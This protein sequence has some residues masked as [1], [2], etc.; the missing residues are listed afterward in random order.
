MKRDWLSQ[1]LRCIRC[2]GDG[3]RLEESGGVCLRCQAKYGL[4]GEAVSFLDESAISTYAIDETNN[5]SDHPYDGNAGEL[6]R[7]VGDAGGWVL[8]CG[9]GFKSTSYSHVVQLE[10][11]PYPQVD[12][13]APNQELPFRDGCFDCVF[14][15]NVLEHVE[16]PFA[17]ASELCRVLKPRGLLY[18]DIPFLQGEHGYPNHYFNATR[19]GLLR[20]FPTFSVRGHHVPLSGHP[21]FMLQHFIEVYRHGLP[22]DLAEDFLNLKMRDVLERSAT[23]WLDSPVC[24]TLSETAQWQIASTTQAILQKTDGVGT[25]PFDAATLPGFA[26]T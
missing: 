8:D 25:T 1:N 21:I 5:V 7:Q 10:I 12:V 11:K 2:H 15:L 17:S 9:A 26:D 3:I 4:M 24:A 19:S 16:N 23:E 20:L 14:S 13:L 18:V 6:I 22:V